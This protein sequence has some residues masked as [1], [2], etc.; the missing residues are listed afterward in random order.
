MNPKYFLLPINLIAQCQDLATERECSVEQIICEQFERLEGDSTLMSGVMTTAGQIVAAMS[1]GE[2]T[3]H[4]WPGQL[5]DSVCV[6][7]ALCEMLERCAETA[8]LAMPE[9]ELRRVDQLSRL[10]GRDFD[11]MMVTELLSWPSNRPPPA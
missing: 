6:S 1:R 5:M 4:L 11:E 3:D 8:L 7:I 10:T 9:L 2:R